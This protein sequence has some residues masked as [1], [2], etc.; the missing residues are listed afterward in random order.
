M[1]VIITGGSRGIGKAIAQQFVAEGNTILLVARNESLLKQAAGDLSIHGTRVE[2]HIADLGIKDQVRKCAEWAL[3]FGTPDI[4]VNNAGSFVPGNVS[5]EE[6][7]NLEL[8]LEVNLLSAYN[9]T[10]ALLP[11][12]I[13]KNSGHIF[14][15]SS[16]AGLKAYS[17]GGS[18]SISKYAL[19]G[20]SVNLRAEL[21]KTGIKVTTIFPGAVLTD[22]WNGF[23]NSNGRIMEAEDIAKMVYACTGLTKQATVEDIIIRPQAGDL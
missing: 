17:G 6:D 8:M 16:I 2:Y 5:D 20:F 3:G 14:N 21:M 19:N 12:M 18:Y 4:L 23:D 7:G 11:S 22:S 1:I 15:I 9:L 13:K 10:R